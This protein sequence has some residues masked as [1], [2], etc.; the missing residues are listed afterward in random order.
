[1]LNYKNMDQNNTSPKIVFEDKDFRRTNRFVQTEPPKITQWV[2]KYFS[3]YIKDE[4]SANYALVG[5]VVLMF[6]ISIIFLSMGSGK[7]NL[8]PPIMDDNFVPMNK[9]TRN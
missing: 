1:M 8:P 3:K 7:N 5:F 9:N 2:M 6:I 4:K